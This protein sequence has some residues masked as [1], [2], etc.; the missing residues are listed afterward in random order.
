MHSKTSKDDELKLRNQDQRDVLMPIVT[1]ALEDSCDPAGFMAN[2][3]FGTKM[4]VLQGICDAG[5]T[6]P[7][8]FYGR[9]LDFGLQNAP[10]SFYAFWAF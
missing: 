8:P 4:T 3:N 6:S 5:V 9:N 1:R 10:M 2:L 7:V